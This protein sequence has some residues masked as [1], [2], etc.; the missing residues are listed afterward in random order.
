MAQPKLTRQQ[1]AQFLPTQELIKAFETLF[2][3]TAETAPTNIDELLQQIGT[4]RTANITP[5][6]VRLLDLEQT[7]QRK[8]NLTDILTRLD[9]LE[10]SLNRQTNL[11]DIKN[12][13]NDIK[14]F[15]GI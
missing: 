4:G 11:T 3:Y 6:L 5:L 12:Q 13:L 2:N 7:Q 14:T 15:L 10:A 1:L 9:S 8:P